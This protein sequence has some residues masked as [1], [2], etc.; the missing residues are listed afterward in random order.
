MLTFLDTVQRTSF[1][2]IVFQLEFI[3]LFSYSTYA[4][5]MY[6]QKKPFKSQ[7]VTHTN[8]CLSL[9]HTVWN[10]TPTLPFYLVSPA[11]VLGS[12]GTI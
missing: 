5:S 2:K 1:R 9:L 4:L 7:K 3:F 10:I 11:A 8:A 12:L 6:K